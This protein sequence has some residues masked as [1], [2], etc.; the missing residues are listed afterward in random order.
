VYEW[1]VGFGTADIPKVYALPDLPR[2]WLK[3]LADNP[4]ATSKD[5]A[6]YCG[7]VGDWLAELPDR[8]TPASVRRLL[9]DAERAFGDGSCRHDTMVTATGAL[10]AMGARGK[11]VYD[12]VYE[13]EVLFCGAVADNRDG[14]WEYW[15]AV[16][17]AV[18]QW[19]GRKPRRQW[20]LAPWL[21]EENAQ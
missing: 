4:K 14:E 13:L 6:P 17:G 5:G 8:P 3:A 16:E 2:A 10:V 12:A 9:R 19:G 7:D 11:A 20:P 1:W 21:T 15:S 18:K